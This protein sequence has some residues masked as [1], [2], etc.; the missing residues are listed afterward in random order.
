MGMAKKSN[1]I[2][3]RTQRRRRDLQHKRLSE[4]PFSISAAH[5]IEQVSF[6]CTG[7]ISGKLT[8]RRSAFP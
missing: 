2:R 3:R 4:L 5:K 6:S 8:N 7:P 1:K